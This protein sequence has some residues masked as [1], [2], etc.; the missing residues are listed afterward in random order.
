[1]GW[2][3]VVEVGWM[4]RV[5]YVDLSLGMGWDGLELDGNRGGE[6]KGRT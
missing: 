6:E 3:G 2:C 1:M 4:G 5:G